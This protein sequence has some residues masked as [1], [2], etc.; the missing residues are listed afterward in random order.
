MPATL[1]DLNPTT[2]AA[3]ELLTLVGSGFAAGARVI[4]A[5]QV[6]TVS[7]VTPT[8]VSESEIRSIVPDILRDVAGDYQVS[9][10]N[11]AEDPSN[12]LALEL[13][14]LPPVETVYPL[15]TLAALKLALGVA[16]TETADDAKYQ[17]LINIA[18]T[19]ISGYCGRQFRL[20][21]YSESYDGDGTGLL[22]LKNTPIVAVTALSI[23]GEAVPESDFSVYDEYLRCDDDGEYSARLRSSSRVFPLGRKNIA[24]TY[25]AGYAAVPAEISH[26]CILQISYLVN[27]LTRQGIVTEGNTIAGVQTTFSSG[28]LAPAVRALCNRYR[29]QK[30]AVV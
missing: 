11:V 25:T 21:P 9:V 28:L 4:Y 19:A 2:A 3:G 22:R 5:G 20:L 1:T 24:V 16:P 14:A 6:I 23:G 7:D 30:V 12:A 29:R 13:Y 27:T 18:S 26:A 15:C 17:E 10:A 8:V